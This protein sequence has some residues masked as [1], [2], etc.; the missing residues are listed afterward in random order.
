MQSEKVRTK[1]AGRTS[2]NRC[3]PTSVEPACYS[4]V[5][6]LSTKL[7]TDQIILNSDFEGPYMH[8]RFRCVI[9]N[10]LN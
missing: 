8:A 6:D 9:R 2:E 5:I 1:S 3:G 4:E 7:N 10:N